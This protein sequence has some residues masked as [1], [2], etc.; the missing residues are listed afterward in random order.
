MRAWPRLVA[1][2]R[3]A[4]ATIIALPERSTGDRLLQLITVS[5]AALAIRTAR[6]L[7]E[8]FARILDLT[9]TIVPCAQAAVTWL[10]RD[11]DDRERPRCVMSRRAADPAAADA[12]LAGMGGLLELLI[13]SGRALEIDDAARDPRLVELLPPGLHVTRLVGI[14]MT[15]QGEVV[16]GIFCFDPQHPVRATQRTAVTFLALQATMAMASVRMHADA[17][18]RERSARVQAKFEQVLHLATSEREMVEAAAVASAELADDAR[19]FVHFEDE[20]QQTHRITVGGA[21]APVLESV[22]GCWAVRRGGPY[23][24]A[25]AEREIHCGLCPRGD[26][27]RSIFC[28][29]L[30]VLGRT[31]GVLHLS[32]SQPDAFPAERR[33]VL[34]RSADQLKAALGGY[35]LLASV[36]RQAVTDPLTGLFNQRYFRDYLERQLALARRRGEKICLL[37]IDIDKFKPVNDT[38]GHDVGDAVL[39]AFARVLLREVRTSDVVARYGGEEFVV[40]LPNTDH[41]GGLTTAEKIRQ[42]TMG[43]A[44]GATPGGDFHMTV[45]VGLAVFPDN[46]RAAEELFRSADNAMYRAK[47]A[48]RNRVFIAA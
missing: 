14:P 32:S 44:I 9:G 48:G 25:D 12:G 7:D 20:E 36:Q 8:F 5:E 28:M 4:A 16:G 2:L 3:A 19:A 31:V 30:T 10:D 22:Q 24:C 35:R 40:V 26:S 23:Y 47:Q 13:R 1:S 39:R 41:V 43:S 15:L 42:A 34:A 18:Q 38:Y 11:R 37:M 21:A 45:S 17:A 6:A 27:A 29:P 46:G 33:G